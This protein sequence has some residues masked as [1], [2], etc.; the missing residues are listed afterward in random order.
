MAFV[1]VAILSGSLG[2]ALW[3]APVDAHEDRTGQPSVHGKT[4]GEWSAAWWQWALAG[5]EGKN[6]VKDTTGEF[7]DDN[8][9][10]G[11][12][13]FLAGSFGLTGVE[14]R[15][16]IPRQRALFYPLI[17]S[18]WIDC[19]G[20]PDADLSDAEVRDR[21]VSIPAFQESGQFIGE[22]RYEQ[23]GDLGTG[24][25]FKIVDEASGEAADRLGVSRRSLENWEQERAMPHAA[26]VLAH[27]ESIGERSK[28]FQRVG[29]PSPRF[30]AAQFGLA[31]VEVFHELRHAETGV[32]Q[33]FQP[34][35]PRSL[36]HLDDVAV[37]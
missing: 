35:G 4:Y 7:C 8:Q 30:E 36:A 19:P 11:P 18:F 6:A 20:T 9:P 28:P 12:V 32:P 24:R 16:T 21:I 29:A 15:C 25:M 13:W 31:N 10:R 2:F 5:P 33:M 14:R 22:Q 3:S 27:H 34:I 37:A 26:L 1:A 17:N 23:I